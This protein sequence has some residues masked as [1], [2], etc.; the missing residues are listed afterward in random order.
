MVVR[1]RISLT[2][3]A[4]VFVTTTVVDWLPIFGDERLAEILL[5]EIE[6]TAELQEVSIAGYVVMPS[7]LHAML[8]FKR[9]EH[10]SRFMQALKSITSRQILPEVS[11]QFSGHRLWKPRF[12]DLIIWSEGQFK[13]KIEYIHNNPVKTGIVEQAIDYKF[14]SARDWLLDQ[15][16]IIAVDRDWKWTGEAERS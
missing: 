4:L 8:G 7:H 9:I 1:R 6:K 16:G 2:G 12:D 11:V 13:T 5:K 15:P 10:L 3:P 14:S